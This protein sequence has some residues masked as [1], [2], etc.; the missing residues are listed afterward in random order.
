MRRIH[1]QKQREYHKNVQ[2]EKWAKLSKKFKKQKSKRSEGITTTELKKSTF[3]GTIKK[4]GAPKKECIQI[5][6]LKNITNQ[7]AA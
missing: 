4:I 6:E 2:S 5:E 7:E 3:F 1:R